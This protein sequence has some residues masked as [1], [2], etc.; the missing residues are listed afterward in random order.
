M[1]EERD[2]GF[3]MRDFGGKQVV[4][5]KGEGFRGRELQDPPS[6]KSEQRERER[7]V[8]ALFLLFFSFRSSDAE[9]LCC[10][11]EKS[12]EKQAAGGTSY[13]CRVCDRRGFT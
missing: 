4:F 13:L 1:S 9:H 11:E 3:R 7:G 12:R 10:T 2:L 5:V 8:L 6:N